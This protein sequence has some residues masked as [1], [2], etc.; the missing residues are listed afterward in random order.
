VRFKLVQRLE[1]AARDLLRCGRSELARLALRL[2]AKSGRLVLVEAEGQLVERFDEL[3]ELVKRGAVLVAAP[4]S[5]FSELAGSDPQARARVLELARE[6]DLEELRE[7]AGILER[8]LPLDAL[9]KAALI[10]QLIAMVE[11]EAALQGVD[12]Q[13]LTRRLLLAA[14]DHLREAGLSEQAAKVEERAKQLRTPKPEEAEVVERAALEL[15]AKAA[16]GGPK[17]EELTEILRSLISRSP[18]RG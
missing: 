11:A 3:R 12:A 17:P 4:P 9:N 15:A 10:A 2:Y 13:P 6:L 5:L 8:E 18:A 7:A 16:L 1:E 14:A